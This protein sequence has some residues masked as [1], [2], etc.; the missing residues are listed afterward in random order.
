MKQ[1]LRFL[2]DDEQKEMIGDKNS[3]DS[4]SVNTY[5]Q[6][7]WQSDIQAHNQLHGIIG[8]ENGDDSLSVI[9]YLQSEWQSNPDAQPTTWYYR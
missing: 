6:S 4:L 8:D 1:V 7:E 9:T 2:K 3:D 5:L